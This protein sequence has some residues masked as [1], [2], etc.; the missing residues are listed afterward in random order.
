MPDGLTRVT[1]GLKPGF[2]GETPHGLT[3]RNFSDKPLTSSNNIYVQCQWL[4]AILTA[5]HDSMFTLGTA[6]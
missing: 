5:A 3:T 1:V 2:T 4:W 6:D